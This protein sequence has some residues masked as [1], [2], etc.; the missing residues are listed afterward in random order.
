MSRFLLARNRIIQS[1]VFSANSYISN[2]FPRRNLWSRFMSSSQ[3]S[4]INQNQADDANK[5]EESPQKEDS[6][7]INAEKA[8]NQTESKDESAEK[9]EK[10]EKQLKEYKD[11]YIRALAN[12]ENLRE[13]TKRE[14]EL[15]QQLAIKSFAVDMLSISDILETAV[16]SVP[17]KERQD[18]SNPHLKNLFTGLSMTSSEL[19]ATFKR[20]GLEIFDPIGEKFDPNKHQALFQAE[21]PDKEPGAVFSVTKKGYTLNGIVVR[22]AQVGVVKE[23]S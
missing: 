19:K 13:R 3:N 4:D 21:V 2:Q 9:I 6:D 22:A 5:S 7:Q 14:K 20:H 23:N 11:H 18:D 8:E 16:D 1:R 17:E 15:A 10:L 12:A